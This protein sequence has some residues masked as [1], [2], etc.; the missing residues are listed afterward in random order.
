MSQRH[1]LEKGSQGASRIES[2]ARIDLRPELGIFV[3]SIL[4]ILLVALPSLIWPKT[5]EKIIAAIYTPL[6]DRFGVLYLWLTMGFI[7]LCFC[8]AFSRYGAI[9]FGRAA[10]K[11]EFSLPSWVAMI[12]CSG[13]AGAVMF[14]SIAEPLYDLTS[15]PQHAA[16]MSREAFEWALAYLLL[17]WGPNAWASFFIIALPIAYIFHVRRKPFLRISSAAEDLIG[18]QTNGPLGRIMDVFFIL[19]LLFCTAVTM[20]ISLPTVE[21]ALV[22]VFGIKPAF[23]VQLCILLISAG[24]AGTSVYLGLDRGI[25]WL[26]NANVV[27]ALSM[28]AYGALCG[29]TATL[30]STF[31][32]ALGKMLGNY[33]NMT[34]WTDPF[35][36]DSFPK[37]WTIFYALFWLG[38]GCFMGLFV[39]RISRGRTVREIIL[40]GMFG[41]IAG[42]YLI[43]GVFAS[44]TLW[45]Q[46]TGLVDAVAILNEKGGP[47][48]MMAVLGTLPLAKPLMLVYCVFSTI[49]LATS[50]DSGCY[51]VSSVA[52]RSMPAGCDPDRRHR[53]FWAIAQALLALGLL[54]IGGL[55]V[56][57]IFGNLS[58]ALMAVPGVI[59]TLSWL[60]IIHKE[61]RRLIAE[62]TLQDLAEVQGKD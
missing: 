7:L 44:Y 13:V 56:A 25:K 54:A 43:H 21:A 4:V 39:A 46:Q 14:W 3:P 20:C 47:A 22:E 8:F 52:T 38:Y 5:S 2:P 53:V 35:G 11:P 42:G 28:V 45:A 16:A 62:Q 18:P 27:I 17:H 19:G 29:P 58:G 32:N 51:V 10:E 31:T 12:F 30:F 41:C 40:W 55:G 24:I 37:D 34:F 9:R 60:K 1:E 61:G 23:S 57:K 6:A 48:A 59:L 33:M 26:S 15:P 49:F 36:G 50:V